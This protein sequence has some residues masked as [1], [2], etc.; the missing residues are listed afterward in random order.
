V[1]TEPHSAKL[2]PLQHRRCLHGG[3]GMNRYPSRGAS[4]HLDRNFNSRGQSPE[5]RVDFDSRVRSPQRT[6]R[7][8]HSRPR[9]PHGMCKS[10]LRNKIPKTEGKI[11]IE[12]KPPMPHSISH[13]EFGSLRTRFCAICGNT[14]SGPC[15]ALIAFGFWRDGHHIDTAI[16]MTAERYKQK[17][18][19]PEERVMQ[20]L[21]SFARKGRTV[22]DPR[23][24]AYN[25][26]FIALIKSKLHEIARPVPASLSPATSATAGHPPS[27]PLISPPS[28]I[29]LVDDLK[30]SLGID[31][32]IH[33]VVHKAAKQ[34][35]IEAPADAQLQPLAL[36]CLERIG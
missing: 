26:E 20:S 16:A 36:K 29:K 19:K 4:N 35:G 22:L 14:H 13:I 21:E 31:G 34:V 8:G 24:G 28:L 7:V 5:R 11:K 25:A 17:L 33:A 27:P 15:H 12:S 23:A 9:S 3:F 30:T 18:P 32:E 10:D 1:D 6:V 2:S